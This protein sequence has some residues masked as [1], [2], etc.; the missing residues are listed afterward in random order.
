MGHF[1]AYEGPGGLDAFYRFVLLHF[2][3]GRAMLHGR[4]LEVAFL[5]FKSWRP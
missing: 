3:T 4:F 1:A 2:F 5:E